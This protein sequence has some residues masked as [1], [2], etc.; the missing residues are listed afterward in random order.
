LDGYVYPFIKAKLGRKIKST[1]KYMVGLVV[2]IL[3]IF[4]AAWLEVA[5]RNSP[6]VPGCG[7]ERRAAEKELESIGAPTPSPSNQVIGI[8]F[9]GPSTL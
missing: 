6:L 2:G 7:A 9:F 3:A 5:R 1:E 4:S 8:G